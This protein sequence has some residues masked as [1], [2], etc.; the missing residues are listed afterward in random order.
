[1]L[2]TAQGE[3]FKTARQQKTIANYIYKKCLGQASGF[4][5]GGDKGNRAVWGQA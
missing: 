2:L 4:G 1:M 5:G 3:L